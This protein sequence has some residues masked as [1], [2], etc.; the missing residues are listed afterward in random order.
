VN[1]LNKIFWRYGF[2]CRL[3]GVTRTVNAAWSTVAVDDTATQQTLKSA[4]RQGGWG[5]RPLDQHHRC[6]LHESSVAA[7][8][9][10][11]YL[12]AQRRMLVECLDLYSIGCTSVARY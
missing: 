7:V 11:Y 12:H 2:E 4:L 9:R 3:A 10:G 5:T 6:S 1:H 8:L